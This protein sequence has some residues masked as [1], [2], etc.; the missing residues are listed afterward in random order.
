VTVKGFDD[1]LVFGVKEQPEAAPPNALG[2]TAIDP[3]A[4]GDAGLPSQIFTPVRR[5]SS[6]LLP[7][8]RVECEAADSTDSP[9]EPAPLTVPIDRRP[10]AGLY[11]WKRSGT[12]KG[13]ATGDVELR[14]SGFE[15]RAVRDIKELGPSTN[16]RSL[17]VPG[18]ASDPGVVFTY[19]TV[20]P[21]I[22]GNV[23]VSLFQVDTSPL[24]V[25]Q[26]PPAG[27]DEIR[28]GGPERGVVLKSYKV[29]DAEGDTI[30]VFEPSNGLLLLPLPVRAG[31]D[32][33]ASA[34]DPLSGASASYRAKVLDRQL[35]DACGELIQ[36]WKVQGTQTFSVGEGTVVRD[37]TLVVATGLGGIP[38]ME[39]IDQ[40]VGGELHLEST[41]GQLIPDPL[42]A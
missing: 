28:A 15:Q 37:Y 14:I 2:D 22:N 21:D 12:A 34:V 6:P 16:A 17:G 26:D 24:G 11:K 39:K 7:R 18:S 31:E 41:I 19:E 29:L 30:S 42:P 25:Y 38:V 27:G 8:P 40:T 33:T 3:N 13:P 36:A 5:P 10:K 32:F 9:E 4:L 23:V 1:N 20:Q 35:V